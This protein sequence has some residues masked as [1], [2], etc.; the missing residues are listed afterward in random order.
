M[1]ILSKSSIPISR[2]YRIH[3]NFLKLKYDFQDY[4]QLIK[5]LE[6]MSGIKE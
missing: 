6:K 5:K 1:S 2:E 4:E 3:L